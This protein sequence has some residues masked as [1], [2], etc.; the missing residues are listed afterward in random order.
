MNT[1]N[2]KRALFDGTNTRPPLAEDIAIASGATAPT[3]PPLPPTTAELD[4][5]DAPPLPDA[6]VM[7][8]CVACVWL[9]LF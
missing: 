5:D 7:V 6:V 4:D 8:T 3:P 2:S 1:Y 9:R